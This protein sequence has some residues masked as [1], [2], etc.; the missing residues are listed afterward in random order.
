M[1]TEYMNRGSL[2]DLLH[3]RNK[4]ELDDER[5]FKIAKQIALGVHYLH[6]KQILHC[7]LKS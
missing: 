5:L 7:D 3:S 2:F 6:K 4:P 1:V